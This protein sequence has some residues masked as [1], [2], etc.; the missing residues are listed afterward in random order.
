[1]LPDEISIK[2]LSNFDKETTDNF[3][4]TCKYNYNLV[5]NNEFAIFCEKYDFLPK[6]DKKK[7]F[8]ELKKE[9]IDME[10]D[11]YLDCLN[12][13]T[14]LLYFIFRNCISLTLD[15]LIIKDKLYL[16]KCQQLCLQNC[17]LHDLFQISECKILKIINCEDNNKISIVNNMPNCE[18]LYLQSLSI[19]KLP[20]IPNCKLLFMSYCEIETLPDIKNCEIIISYGNDIDS[21]SLWYLDKCR[22][23]II[24]YNTLEHLTTNKNIIVHLINQD[25]HERI[26]NSFMNINGNHICIHNK[27]DFADNLFEEFMQKNK[28]E[29]NFTDNF[30]N[31][32]W[33][34]VDA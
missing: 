24:E 21:Q 34:L 29:N 10:E 4:M 9:R 23:L 6:D 33:K 5:N 14:Y 19:K 20:E 8:E 7:I 13:E 30:I 18:I 25:D 31:L 3:S 22:L 12:F 1:M 26:P 28:L 15:G 11:I 32:Y 16:P 27:I 17:E 2:I